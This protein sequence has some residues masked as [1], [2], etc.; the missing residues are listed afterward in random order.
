M[1]VKNCFYLSCPILELFFLFN[2]KF[3]AYILLSS[4]L[5]FFKLFDSII[6]LAYFQPFFFQVVRNYLCQI[7]SA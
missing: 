3:V 7:I 5:F 2:R 6:N 1:T 4:V